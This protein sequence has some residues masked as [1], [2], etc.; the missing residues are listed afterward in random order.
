MVVRRTVGIGDDVDALG[1]A[2][3]ARRRGDLDLLPFA[4]ADDEAHAGREPPDVVR[5][6]AQ[7][8]LG[9]GRADVG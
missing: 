1:C 4:F 6:D 8:V 3:G 7:L 9:A 2:V 5:I